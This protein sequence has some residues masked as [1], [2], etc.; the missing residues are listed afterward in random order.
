MRLCVNLKDVNKALIPERYP[1]PTMEELT[2]KVSGAMVFSII[3]FEME[4]S[5][6]AAK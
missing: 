6:T 2:M 5:A 3:D 1:L 4:L